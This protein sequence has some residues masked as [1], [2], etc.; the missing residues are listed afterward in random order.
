MLLELPK[1]A[2]LDCQFCLEH[3]INEET[4]E[5]EKDDATGEPIRRLGPQYA[6]CRMHARGKR[7][8]GCPKGTPEEPLAL[9]PQNEIARQFHEE[10]QATGRFPPDPLVARRAV[11]IE[12][13]KKSCE[14]RRQEMLF[15]R[16]RIKALTGD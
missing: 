13:V 11:I 9:S 7:Q 14:E 15:L 12:A 10:C 3:E 1:L 5:V 6:P 8:L 16:M 2:R 4:W